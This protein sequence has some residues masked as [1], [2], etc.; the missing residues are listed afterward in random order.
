MKIST[1]S[2]DFKRFANLAE[3]DL[4]YLSYGKVVSALKVLA[5][6]ER[7]RRP[8]ETL[9]DIGCGAGGLSQLLDDFIGVEISQ[10]AVAN[11]RRINARRNARFVCGN[12][13]TVP[14]RDGVADFVLSV[15]MLEHTHVP[16]SAIGE[17][18]R[19]TRR[20]ALI[21]VP[22]RDC[23]PFWYDPVNWWRLRRGKEPRSRG[24]FGYG[25]INLANRSEWLR[26]L[27]QTGFRLLDE[28]AYDDSLIGQLEFCAFSF[29][30]PSDEYEDVP[31][32]SL[33]GGK[34]RLV[35]WL[36]RLAWALDIRLNSSFSRCFLVEKV[37]GA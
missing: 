25:H 18:H 8:G 36:H 1:A 11:A 32:Q 2:P 27:D 21:V 30:V 7:F 23:V 5:L 37:A 6:I 17:I 33:S 22:C 28:F 29:A 31:V 9:L 4:R 3:V 35:S 16:A 19:L 13:E 12:A 20:Q 10:R 34:Y 15:N 14:L 24:A 26:M